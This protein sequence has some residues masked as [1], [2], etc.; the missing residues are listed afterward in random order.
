[1]RHVP[2]GFGKVTQPR[3]NRR[4]PQG[5]RRSAGRE[6]N[7]NRQEPERVPGIRIGD[8]EPARD[9][10]PERPILVAARERADSGD[11]R[12]DYDDERR[13]DTDQTLKRKLRRVARLAGERAEQFELQRQ[14]EC[15]RNDEAGGPRERESPASHVTFSPQ[16]QERE[17]AGGGADDLQQRRQSEERARRASIASSQHRKCREEEQY[18]Q[19]VVMSLSDAPQRNGVEAVRR[20]R[21][22]A[23]P[24][25][26]KECVEQRDASQ[27]RERRDDAHDPQRRLEAIAAGE[28]A[29]R[30]DSDERGTIDARR[31]RR[32]TPLPAGG[33]DERVVMRG[34]NRKIRIGAV[35]D[36]VAVGGVSVDVARENDRPREDRGERERRDDEG[37]R[38]R[39]SCAALAARAEREDECQDCE[40]DRERE[41]NED[42]ESVRAP[43]GNDDQRLGH[44]DMRARR[45]RTQKQPRCERAGRGREWEAGRGARRTV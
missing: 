41:D 5:G 4:G 40:R 21:E 29:E 42:H 23:I 18:Q 32:S 36:D 33:V 19:R 26:A 12:G 8:R 30:G 16:A 24:F 31:E 45:G 3:E 17:R 35:D 25:S 27:K 15:R 20:D 39:Q 44:V 10:K 6:G 14:D 38:Q 2:K 34:R 1:M 13:Y 22:A 11:R 7:R 9:R 43:C 37:R 28:D